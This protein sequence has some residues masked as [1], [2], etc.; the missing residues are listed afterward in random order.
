VRLVATS[1]TVNHIVESG[2][3]VYVWPKRS[4]CCGGWSYVLDAATLPPDRVF[5]PIHAEEGIEVW[6]TPGLVAPTELHLELGRR[7]ALRAFWNGQAS[8]G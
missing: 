2:G 3:T 4:R 7:G 6:A 5:E 1:E 8:V